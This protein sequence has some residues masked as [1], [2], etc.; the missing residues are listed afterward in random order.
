MNCVSSVTLNYRH[1][2]G[3]Q[4]DFDFEIFKKEAIA[5]LYARKKMTCTDGVLAPMM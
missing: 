5:G 4:E 1:E 3:A 2:Y